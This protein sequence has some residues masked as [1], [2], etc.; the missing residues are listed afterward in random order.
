MLNVAH[1]K[2][3]VKSSPNLTGLYDCHILFDDSM[4]N[5]NFGIRVLHVKRQILTY[6]FATSFLCL[7]KFSLFHLIG[8][9]KRCL[10]KNIENFLWLSFCDRTTF[11]KKCTIPVTMTFEGQMFLVSYDPISVLYKF[12][13]DISTNG[14]EIKY[15]NMGIGLLHVKRNTRHARSSPNLAHW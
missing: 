2:I 7:L 10:Q 4:R 14:R 6:C 15:R 13:I 8:H 11:K 5:S 3:D 12:H 1:V 9:T